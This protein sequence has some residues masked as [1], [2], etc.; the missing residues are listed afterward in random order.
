MLTLA[1]VWLG[2]PQTLGPYVD[3]TTLEGAKQTIAVGPVASQLAIKMLG[4]NG[5]GFFNTNSAHPFEN[6]DNISNMIQMVSIFLIGAYLVIEKPTSIWFIQI[7]DQPLESET[8]LQLYVLLAAAADP[9]RRL[10]NVY[11]R[12]QSGFASADRIFKYM[13]Q[14]P[15]IQSNSDT[16]PLERH[17]LAPV[18]RPQ[19]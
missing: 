18:C 2:V 12:I 4:T 7:S 9:I 11:T 19:A 16:L 13:D 14:S 6:P 3:A 15:K 5:G 17:R 8:L 10:S 1:Y